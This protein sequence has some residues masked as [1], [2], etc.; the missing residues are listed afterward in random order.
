MSRFDKVVERWRS[1]RMDR[2]IT[3]A[4]WGNYGLTVLVFP[5]AGGD[6]EEVERH[7]M[8]GHLGGLMDDGRIKVYSCDSVAGRAMAA[9]DGDVAYRCWLFNQFQ[10]AVAHEVV[11]AIH[12]DTG[13]PNA[14]TVAGASIGAFNALALVCR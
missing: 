1:D 5:T 14:V 2:E 13:G 8:V 9:N 12:A 10:E 11:A 4:R 7:H 3:L 6:A